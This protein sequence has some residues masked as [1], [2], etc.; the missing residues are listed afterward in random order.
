LSNVYDIKIDIDFKPIEY[1]NFVHNLVEKMVFLED[2]FG[3]KFI[4]VDVYETGKGLHIYFKVE[5]ERKLKNTD[6][7]VIQLALGSDYKREIYNW[8]RVRNGGNVKYW[9]KLFKVKTV[10]GKIVGVE[11]KS[12]LAKDIEREIMRVLKLTKALYS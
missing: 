10:K 3:L 4:N 12:D 2:V 9:N 5:T 7:V 1:A 8:L 11:H 6:I